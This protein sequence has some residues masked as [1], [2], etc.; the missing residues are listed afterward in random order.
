MAHLRSTWPLF[1]CLLLY[2][3][4][5]AFALNQPDG[6]SIPSNGN[7][8]SYLDGEGENIE[9]TTAAATTP[10][11]FDPTCNLTFKVI[12]RGGGQKNSFGWYNVTGS[13]PEISDLHEFLGCNDGVGVEKTL[14]IKTHPAYKGGKIGFFMA[15]TEGKAGN[16]VQF[17]PNGPSAESLGYMY[18]S[19]PQ[20]NDD[21]NG[22]NSY[23]HLVILDSK[24]YPKG[25]YFGWEDLFGGGDNDFED[26]LTRV[27]GISCAGGG[28]PCETGLSG[29]CS[30]GILQ[31]QNGALTC[32]Q[33][34]PKGVE[35]CNAVDDDCNGA[36]DDGDDLCP[37][38]FVCFRGACVKKCTTGE[39]ACPVDLTCETSTGYCVEPT[40]AEKKCPEGSICRKGTCQAP[41]EGVVCP[42]GQVCRQDVCV[43]PCAGIEC[44]GETV[45]E[46]GV[47]KDKC[48]CG[49]CP[50]GKTCA[51]NG[52]CVDTGCEAI[53]CD[54]G[55]VCI[56]G[57]CAD[58]CQNTKC[59]SG[60]ICKSGSCQ[61]NTNVENGGTGGTSGGGGI[62]VSGG[63]AGTTASGGV[64]NGGKAGNNASG[65]KKALPHVEE[66]NIPAEEDSSCGC[67]MVGA[68]N[69]WAKGVLLMLVAGGAWKRQGRAR[70]QKRSK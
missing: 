60:Q 65:G 6:S 62:G 13:K 1:T 57:Q 44:P 64:S 31:C 32:L 52:L 9:P 69:S 27:E 55:K 28:E 67:R 30:Q 24:K 66:E 25:F 19:E 29:V 42:G 3:P 35:K 61:E 23:I 48:G 56:A 53:T 68:E 63:Q 2:F 40:C 39:F 58:A 17:G 26:L 33:S 5:T 10:Q 7:L 18:Y 36:I 14:A 20:Y 54:D 12:A 34:A 37:E 21:N 41:C 70:L 47:C 43:D 4:T 16:C 22:P 59:P 38:K 8:K 49:S 50:G 11:T 15:S 51:A 45:C 46:G